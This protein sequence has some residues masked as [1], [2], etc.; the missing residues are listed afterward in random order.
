M[1][2]CFL[3][4]D[5][6]VSDSFY[7]ILLVVTR[8][9]L[10]L[11]LMA[12]FCHLISALTNIDDILKVALCQTFVIEPVILVNLMIFLKVGLR[13][14][15]IWDFGQL[16]AKTSTIE[17]VT[18]ANLMTVRPSSSSQL[19]W[20]PDDMLKVGLCHQTSI[21]LNLMIFLKVTAHHLTSYSDQYWWQG[22]LSHKGGASIVSNRQLNF[23]V[24]YCDD[25]KWQ[26]HA[27]TSRRSQIN[28]RAEVISNV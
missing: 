23:L 9:K 8:L 21:L 13:R 1:S 11:I 4:I 15:L 28:I 3:S 2:I 5:C 17:P 20:Q 25:R 27:S 7:F 18:L 12:C 6:T 14:F 10:W 19:L 16:F 26:L 22:W 24:T